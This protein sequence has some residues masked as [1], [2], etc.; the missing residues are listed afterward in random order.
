M[1]VARCLFRRRV[2]SPECAR[3][4]SSLPGK[5]WARHRAWIAAIL[6]GFLT[7][8]STLVRRAAPMIFIALT[9]ICRIGQQREAIPAGADVWRRTFRV[10]MSVLGRSNVQWPLGWADSLG[11]GFRTLLRPR[12]GALWFAPDPLTAFVVHPTASSVSS[13]KGDRLEKIAPKSGERSVLASEI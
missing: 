8:N 9:P 13:G 7:G 10:R 2:S 6:L 12:T 1:A 3:P 11:P 5:C 4:R